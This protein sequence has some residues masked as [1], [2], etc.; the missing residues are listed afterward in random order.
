MTRRPPPTG[1]I[2]I[3]DLHQ[4]L[5]GTSPRPDKA[6]ERLAAVVFAHLG[7]V[8]VEHDRLEPTPGG[9][10]SHQLDFVSTHP[11]GSVA[12]LFAQCKHWNYKVSQTAMSTLVGVQTQ[13]KWDAAV[14][15]TQ[16]GFTRGA[17]QVAADQDIAM[18]VLRPYN[19]ASDNGRWFREINMTIIWPF[20]SV[21]DVQFQPFDPADAPALDGLRIQEW[22]NVW[23]EEQRPAETFRELWQQG[24]VE[25]EDDRTLRGT[26]RLSNTRLIALPD[27]RFVPITGMSWTVLVDR[28]DISTGVRAEGAPVFWLE[29]IG[30]DG[31]VTLGRVVT[32]E[33]L[34]LWDF[35]GKRVVRNAS[36]DESVTIVPPSTSAHNA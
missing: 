30:S 4:R 14:V 10:A 11:D 35:E 21:S 28:R 5:Y 22:M 17:R 20:Q 6:Y 31:E 36:L 9:T 7:W 18:V 26:L 25:R 2:S 29:Q 34:K 15:I 3:E 16:I 24:H 12:H 23:D 33:Q 13:L 8:D 19:P 1:P 32:E 27:G